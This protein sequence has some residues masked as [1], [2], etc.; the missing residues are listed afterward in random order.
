VLENNPN[1]RA[2]QSFENIARRLCG[3]KVPYLDLAV[4]RDNLLVRIR[5]IFTK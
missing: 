2:A 1:S 5:K 4:E 3:E